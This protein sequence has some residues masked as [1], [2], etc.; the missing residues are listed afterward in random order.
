MEGNG[1][2]DTTR[3]N[4]LVFPMGIGYSIPE[5]DM[6][7]FFAR[8]LDR[9]NYDALYLAYYGSTCH[10]GPGRP[11][12]DPKALFQ[13]CAYG[14]ANDTYSSRKIER[15]CQKDIDYIWLLNGEPA[16]DHTT[17]AAF[18]TGVCKDA[19]EDLFYQHVRYLDMINATNHDVGIFDGTKM[20]SFANRYTF[21][22]RGTV[23][24]NLAKL[25]EKVQ[26]VFDRRGICGEVTIGSL[27][28]AVRS[29]EREMADLRIDPV[30]GK[31]HRKTGLQ[32]DWEE[33]SGILEKWEKYENQ[34]R[35]MGPD[36]NS[37]SRTDPDATFMRMKDDHMRNGQLKP[38]YNL[39][40]CVNSEFITGVGIFPDR[41]DVGT[42][43]PFIDFLT[44]MHGQQYDAVS[45]DAGYE[46][47][48]NYRHLDSLGIT[49]YIKPTCYETMNTK[50]FRQQIGRHENMEHVV[51]GDYYLCADQRKLVF[52]R[53]HT[54]TGKSGA[55]QTNRVYRCEGCEGCEL[56]QNC[57]RSKDADKPKEIEINPEFIAYRGVSL[58]NITSE[59]GI[60]LRTN[61]S[62]QVEGTFGVIK[63]DHHY[64]R[65]LCGGTEKVLSELHLL[66]I[67]YNI[68]K[69]Y[70]KTMDG[71]LDHHLFELKE[72]S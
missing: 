52:A 16:P 30:S 58:L 32:R 49:S 25:P 54:F 5:D 12:A 60:Q 57:C 36:R 9:L 2:Q 27:K 45:A 39:Q 68:R 20:E 18:R 15:A 59:Y 10:R 23:E 48:L 1:W 3:D 71:R 40:I 35:T 6:V 70:R 29:L 7:R 66:G 21:V 65:F 11:P 46:S 67:G 14:Y 42:L 22:W 51:D 53:E 43:V 24:K 63:W 13:V 33:L 69:H 56:R 55:E 72:T 61:R 38:A 47:L 17:I 64:Y 62:I 37:Y 50:K 34:L 8:D 41:N 19:I 28:G 26:T 4:Q 31:G 44:L